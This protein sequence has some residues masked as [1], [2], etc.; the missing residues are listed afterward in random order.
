MCALWVA[1]R[2]AQGSLA[3]LLVTSAVVAVCLLRAASG[4][5]RLK[6]GATAPSSPDAALRRSR[7]RARRRRT[8][9]WLYNVAERKL[10]PVA[11]PAGWAFFLATSSL[12]RSGPTLAVPHA[13]RVL[14][15]AP[16]PDDETIGC[17]GTIAQLAAKGA[18]VRVVVVTD[19]EGSLL[20][21]C[22]TADV[23]R[24]RRRRVTEAC[25]RLG[26][27]R[28]AFLGLPDGGLPGCTTRLVKLL[29]EH[30]EELLPD[31]LFA[32]WPLD[33]HPDHRAVASCIA[34]L[35]LPASTQI[36]TYEVWASLLPNRLVDVSAW[37]QDK[38]DAL[39]CHCLDEADASAH[40]ALQRWRSLHGLGGRGYAE[41]FLALTPERH[42]ELL[43]EWAS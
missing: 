42:R 6:Q 7:R 3:W 43:E 27:S 39:R 32:P 21:G 5:A 17:G 13:S 1:L 2:W 35:D 10:R 18:E 28:L 37:W 11:P 25:R 15:V 8:L 4:Q 31:L 14:V 34:R 38:T 36:W 40:L 24:L 19:G 26:V 12:A 22:G 33:D 30:V 20:A 29:A 41:A 16:H 23:G 9:W